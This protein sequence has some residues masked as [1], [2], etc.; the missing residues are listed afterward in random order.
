MRWAAV[1]W[2]AVRRA[3][4]RWAAARVLAALALVGAL[5]CQPE[6]VTSA[7][8]PAGV[9]AEPARAPSRRRL[10]ILA[11]SSLT[12]AFVDLRDD[13]ES[14]VPELE[15]ELVFAGSQVLRLQ[16]EQGAEFDVFA[17][18]N[19]EHA[20]ALAAEG[21][22]ADPRVFAAGELALIVPTS[23]SI[24][25]FDELPRAERLVVGTTS[26][27]VG[28][29]TRRLFARVGERRG[30][31]L[32]Q[33]LEGRVVSEESNVRLVRAKVE[34]GEAD[35]AFV[36]ATDLVGPAGEH[37][38]GVRQVPIPADLRVAAQYVV[39]RAPHSAASAAFIERLCAPPARALLAARGF[40]S[41]PC[42]ALMVD[43][44]S[45]GE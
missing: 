28:R 12:E 45:Q 19:A 29:Y 36:Y 5:G 39:G 23:S 21:L 30:P 17:S 34:L 18:A 1:R 35:A 44:R 22:L 6:D 37:A 33:T 16:I 15:L 31:A 27:P 25:S 40:R 9:V 8:A 43:A 3:A 42:R 20:A 26:V 38:R 2:A 41:D 10:V 4:V 14:T 24:R 32:Q 11:A 13:F 7:S